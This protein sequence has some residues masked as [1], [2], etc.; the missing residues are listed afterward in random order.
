LEDCYSGY[1]SGLGIE[2]FKKDKKKADEC[3]TKT[4]INELFE[5]MGGCEETLCP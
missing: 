3:D 5:C 2:K 1:E 4:C